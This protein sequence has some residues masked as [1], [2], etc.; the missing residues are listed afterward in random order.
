MLRSSLTF[1]QRTDSPRERRVTRRS[2]RP[3]VEL[4]EGRQLLAAALTA[5]SVPLS[6]APVEGQVFTGVVAQFSDAD[7]NTDPTAYAVAIHWG[8][9]QTSRGTVSLD[10]KGGFDVSGTHTYAGPGAFRITAQIADKDADPTSVSTTNVV[11]EA[12][13]TAS[14]TNINATQGTRLLNVVVGTFTDADGALKASAFSATIDWGDGRTS[15]GRVVANKSGGFAVHGSHTYAAPGAYAVKVD[16]RQGPLGGPTQFFTESDLISDGPIAS[17]HVDPL[18]V[19]PWGLVAGGGGPFWDG[20][21]GTGTSSLFDGAGN[22]STGL[23]FVTVPPPA[24]SAPGTTSAPTG[25]VFNGTPGFVVSFTNA[26]G[27]TTSGPAAFI[28]ATEDGTISGWNPKVSPTGSSPSVQAVLEV[29]NSASGAVYKGLTEV[30]FANGGALPAGQYL[31]ATNF[32][33]GNI[34]VFDS[35]F[36]PVNLPVGAFQDANLPTGYA[37]FG[38]HSIGNAVY[39]SYA[40]QN[41]AKHDDVEGAGNGFVDVYSLSGALLTRLGGP[42]VQPELNSPWG[43]VQAPANFGAF[44]KDILVGNFGDSHI[45]AFDPTTGAFLGQLSD[46]QGHPLVL[47]GGEQG[48][49]TKGLW[50][51]SFGNGN[52]AGSTNTLFFNSGFND[53]RDG[54]FGSLTASS[55]ATAT[56]HS[57]ASVAPS[58]GNPQGHSIGKGSGGADPIDLALASMFENAQRPHHHRM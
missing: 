33:S 47:A 56:A 24:G 10:P 39:V 20:N 2:H 43:I 1:R 53:E 50:G 5:S 38:I 44:S 16:I 35:S 30:T 48:A 7:H 36:K 31:F 12:A 22:V 51:L 13:I 29:D 11:S 52:G 54:L 9:G 42:G 6:P 40:K 4:L 17:D 25:V 34:D 14:G 45:S 27:V 37:P 15:I 57:V 26:Q 55:A 46:A 23:P 19:N 32:H 3:L 58:P 28:F 21:N 18:L 41:A 49:D 8:D